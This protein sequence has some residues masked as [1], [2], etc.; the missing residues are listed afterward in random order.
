MVRYSLHSMWICD[1][2]TRG[3]FTRS[4]GIG[5]KR[6]ASSLSTSGGTSAELMFIFSANSSETIFMTNSRVAEML[7]SVSLR[8]L[9]PAR[10][11]GQKQTIGGLALTPVK[12]LNG[13]RLRIPSRLRVETNAIGR[14]TIAPI[15][16]L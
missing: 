10:C 12:K 14:G 2:L 15:S 4:L 5:V 16:S 3:G 1:S 7:R 8:G 13:A 11:T 9:G 6:E